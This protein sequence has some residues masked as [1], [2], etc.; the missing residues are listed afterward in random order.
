MTI[1]KRKIAKSI[2]PYLSGNALVGKSA[3]NRSPLMAELNTPPMANN[4]A[5]VLN[6]INST[7]AVTQKKP[8]R[9]Q[10]G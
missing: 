8:D 7:S 2:K 9:K 10:V 5:A 3:I 1:E 6:L 4:A